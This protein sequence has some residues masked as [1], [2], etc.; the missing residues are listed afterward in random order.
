MYEEASKNASQINER[1]R[2]EKWIATSNRAFVYDA[3]GL[4]EEF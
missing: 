4:G 3:S 1:E 2:Y